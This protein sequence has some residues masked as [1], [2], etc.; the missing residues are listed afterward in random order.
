MTQIKELLTTRNK[1]EKEKLMLSIKKRWV[2]K[3]KIKELED[4]TCRDLKNDLLRNQ[5]DF[6]KTFKKAYESQETNK[7]YSVKNTAAMDFNFDWI[8]I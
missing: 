4:E 6:R 3:L 1:G 7:P 5:A 2:E 8:F